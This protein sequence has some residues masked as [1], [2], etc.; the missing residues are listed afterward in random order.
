M[1]VEQLIFTIIAFVLFVFTFFKMIRKN[2]TDYII[3]SFFFIILKNVKTKSNTS[4]RNSI[5][6]CRSIIEKRIKSIINYY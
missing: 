4:L 5:Q 1:I 2:E 6:F 3:V